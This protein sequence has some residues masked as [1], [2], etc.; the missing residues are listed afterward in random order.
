MLLRSHRTQRPRSSGEP[1]NQ[2]MRRDMPAVVHERQHESDQQVHAGLLDGHGPRPRPD[3]R[4]DNLPYLS[5][6]STC[7]EHSP[8]T[9]QRADEQPPRGKPAKEV[10]EAPG[11]ATH[12]PTR[13][14]KGSKKRLR[15]HAPDQAPKSGKAPANRNQS[16]VQGRSTPATLEHQRV[17]PRQP[18]G[19]GLLVIDVWDIALITR[20]ADWPT[21]LHRE[22]S[23]AR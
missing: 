8:Q 14:P 4:D 6:S 11:D 20:S 1:G 23:I 15:R 2:T 22:A 12:A 16:N 10:R 21:C 5:R 7:R 19:I 9:G 17:H 18:A 13:A 3:R